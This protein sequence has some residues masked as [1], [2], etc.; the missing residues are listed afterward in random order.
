[1]LLP[2]SIFFIPIPGTPSISSLTHPNSVAAPGKSPAAPVA[3]APAGKSPAPPGVVTNPGN[4]PAAPNLSPEQ[5]KAL[6]SFGKGNE[7]EQL[8][9][10]FGGTSPS[11]L[12]GTAAAERSLTLGRI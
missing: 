3:A 7:L 9:K 10:E 5:E 4:S 11:A 2:L 1:L 6:Q 12:G 8:L